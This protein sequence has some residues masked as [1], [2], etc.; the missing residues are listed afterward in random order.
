MPTP[1]RNYDT[2][3]CCQPLVVPGIITFPMKKI[4]R[5]IS[6][7]LYHRFIIIKTCK[8]ATEKGLIFDENVYG[9]AI[10]AW[11]C[12]SF[13]YDKYNLRY[14]CAEL[15]PYIEKANYRKK[16]IKSLLK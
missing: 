12:R 11:N 3:F 16:K 4:F 1:Y 15:S 8:E 5:F 2:W 6:F 10:N 9:D 14:R 7:Y 13:W